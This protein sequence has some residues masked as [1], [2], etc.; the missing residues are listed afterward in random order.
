VA[1]DLERSDLQQMSE[2]S[3][4]MLRGALDSFVQ[5]EAARAE[6]VLD[7]DDAVDALYGKILRAMTSFMSEHPGEVEPAIRIIHVAKYIERIADHATNIAEE[8][9]FMVRGEDVRHAR[10]HR[11]PKVE[12]KKS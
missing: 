8:V 5:G 10:T 3:Q 11:P 2:H 6:R 12:P 9:I 7:K 1:K 4:E